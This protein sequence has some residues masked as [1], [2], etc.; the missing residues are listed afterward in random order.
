MGQLYLRVNGIA[1]ENL[2]IRRKM[3]SGAFLDEH[4]LVIEDPIIGK[5]AIDDSFNLEARTDRRKK[6]NPTTVKNFL[7]MVLSIEKQPS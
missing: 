5:F 1:I 2:K 4:E 3:R 7:A 6:W